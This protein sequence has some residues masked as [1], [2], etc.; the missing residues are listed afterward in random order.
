MPGGGMKESI[1]TIPINESFGLF[2]GCPMC[3]L[4]RKADLASLEF[5]TGPAMMEPDVRV[6]T[7]KLGFCGPHLNA[8]YAR[9]NKLSLALMLESHLPELDRALFAPASEANEKS[10]A[11]KC[12][13]DAENAVSACYIC[14]RV[15]RTMRHYYDNV[16]F[17]W[18]SEPDFRGKFARQP[19][20]CLPHYAGLLAG[21]DGAL[22][23][24]ARAE[25]TRELAG[26][27]RA[28]LNILSRDVSEFCA[29]FDYRNAGKAL[30]QEAQSSVGR[31]VAFLSGIPDR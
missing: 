28:Y 27:C 11:A 20:F 2:D 1:Y 9:Q 30:S 10:A 16:V 7:N 13:P 18:K 3:D 21:A 23:K 26:A 14:G 31:A 19:F 25:F 22:P 17:L 5:V 4:E 8:M 24:R 6:Q 29:S 12:G 15:E